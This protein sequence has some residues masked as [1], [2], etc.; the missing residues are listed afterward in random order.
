[1]YFAAD[2]TERSVAGRLQGAAFTLGQG[3]AVIFGEAGMFTAQFSGPENPMGMNAPIARQNP[4][5]LLNAMHWLS[6]VH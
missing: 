6:G 5:L 4:Q 1:M 3:R 2:S